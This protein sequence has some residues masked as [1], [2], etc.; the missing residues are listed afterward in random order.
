MLLNIETST[1]VCSITVQQEDRLLGSTA[2]YLE[3][4]HSSVLPIIIGQ[5]LDQ[6]GVDKS[7]L[8]AIGV[9]AGPG[10]YT[11]LRIGASTAKGLAY[12]L[13]VPLL[14]INALDTMIE[15]VP[16]TLLLDTDI[17]LPMLDARRMEV[18]T[19]AVDHSKRELL[20]VH[21]LILEAESFL[22][23]REQR[24]ILFGSGASKAIDFIDHP[25][26]VF[27]DQITP[28]AIGM[29]KLAYQKFMAADFEDVAYFEPLYLKEFQTKK[30]KDLLRP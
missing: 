2:L 4:S 26:K 15:Q 20:S 12:A 29:V 3:K 25:N 21:A 28:S 7:E 18:Y 24:L 10:S 1:S 14:S 22:Q 9:S 16:E 11:G 19:K 27:V 13:G 23:F 5:L 6:V 30:S 17:L 8:K